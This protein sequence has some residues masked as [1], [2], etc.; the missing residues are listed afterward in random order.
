[1]EQNVTNASARLKQPAKRGDGDAHDAG[2]DVIA[3]KT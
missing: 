1:M 3:V 2:R